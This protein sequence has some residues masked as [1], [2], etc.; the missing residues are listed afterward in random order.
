MESPLKPIIDAK[1]TK[2]KPYV[3]SEKNR[4]MMHYQGKS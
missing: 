4:K 2:I 1:K 3:P